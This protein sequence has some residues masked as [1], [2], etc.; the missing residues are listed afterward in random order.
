MVS[1]VTYQDTTH[2]LMHACSNVSEVHRA[3]VV[4]TIGL[5]YIPYIPYKYIH[6]CTL[7][8]VSQ[9]IH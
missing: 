9:D 3:R 2:V 8:A 4:A 6:G 1:L 5:V 7:E